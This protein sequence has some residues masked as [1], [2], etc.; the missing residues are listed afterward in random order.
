[1]INTNLLASH[2]L[3][4]IFLCHMEK[5]DDRCEIDQIAPRE[6]VLSKLMNRLQDFCDILQY[7]YI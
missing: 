5:Q 1:M 2:N 7:D 3:I 4:G 6:I